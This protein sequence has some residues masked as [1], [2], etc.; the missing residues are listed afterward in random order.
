[1]FG[2][3]TENHL[4]PRGSRFGFSQPKDQDQD[5]SQPKPTKEGEGDRGWVGCSAFAKR[6]DHID[7]TQRGLVDRRLEAALDQSRQSRMSDG[8]EI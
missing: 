8:L 4:S 3:G 7:T 2:R 5:Q 1:M 6:M